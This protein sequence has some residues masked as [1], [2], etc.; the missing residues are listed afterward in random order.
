MYGFSTGSVW[1]SGVSACCAPSGAAMEIMNTKAAPA[2]RMRGAETN[3]M[4]DQFQCG[5]PAS[6]R[7]RGDASLLRNGAAR[8][9]RQREHRQHAAQVGV[10]AEGGVGTDG[11]QPGVRVV[12]TGRQADPGPAA[13]P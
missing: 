9:I 5:K 7:C 3:V 1:R 6:P 10:L 4:A 8:S 2:T 12:Q 11:A 13:D